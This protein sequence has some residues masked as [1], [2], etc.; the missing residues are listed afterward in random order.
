MMYGAFGFGWVMMLL[1]MV[2]PVV[3]I[4]LL[5][6][7]ALGGFRNLGSSLNNTANP[8]HGSYSPASATLSTSTP[9]RYCSHCGTGLHADWSH[10]PQCG[11]PIG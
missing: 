7:W 11:A 8:T 10:C 1:F 2:V 6:A 3:L 9:Q 5:I 4:I